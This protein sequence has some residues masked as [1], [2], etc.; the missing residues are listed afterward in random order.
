M[1]EVQGL[2]ASAVLAIAL[3]VYTFWPDRGFE[4]QSQKTLLESLIE[5]RV[6]LD[7]NL[8][9]LAFEFQEGKYPEQDYQ[10]QRAQLESEVVQLNLQIEGLRTA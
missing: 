8:R 2:V 7:E 10:T 5:R 3:F 6:Q 9:D 4:H 1:N